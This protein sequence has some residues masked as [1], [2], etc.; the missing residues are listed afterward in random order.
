MNG[1]YPVFPWIIYFLLGIW[2][3][4]QNLSDCRLQKKIFLIAAQ[5]IVIC[6]V[7]AALL[8]I[9]LNLAFSISNNNSILIFFIH[10]LDTSPFSSSILSVFSAGGT[11]L[12]VIIL[13]MKLATRVGHS[14]W[15]KPFNAT[16]QMSLTLYIVHIGIIQLFLLI[17]GRGAMET[18]LEEA[19]IWAMFFCL[20]L[21][22]FA[23]YWMNH[24]G[25]G[26]LEKILRW[27]SK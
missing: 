16:A 12:V 2:L 20:I 15:L 21:I 1:C 7:V 14:K 3:G 10:S 17:S 23:T 8:E 13:S 24:F 6:E 19:W 5:V 27:V 11:A 4:R 18:S 9:L 22:L 25:R 26:P